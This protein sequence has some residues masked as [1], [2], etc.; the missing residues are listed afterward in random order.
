MKIAARGYI[1]V[2]QSNVGKERAARG[3][4]SLWSGVVLLVEM[5]IANLR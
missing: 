5:P 1:I 4:F 3:R 2:E